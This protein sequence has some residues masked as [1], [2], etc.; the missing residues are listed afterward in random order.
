MAKQEQKIRKYI[1]ENPE[2]DFD[3]YLKKEL[4][5]K[6]AREIYNQESA[7]IALAMEIYRARQ[8]KKITQVQLAKTLRM[9]QANIARIEQGEHLPTLSTLA[10]IFNAL[11]QA[12]SVRIG[13]REVCFGQ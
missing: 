7:K 11:G 10:K 9:P 13:K 6:K 5:D 8:K 2:V 3:L 1:K 12:V 4:R